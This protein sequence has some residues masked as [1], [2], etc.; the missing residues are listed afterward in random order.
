MYEIEVKAV[1]FLGSSE[2]SIREA[3]REA[4]EK[5]LSLGVQ[6][7]DHRIQTDLY[8]QHPSLDYRLT[9]EAFRIRCQEWRG[10]GRSNMEL[11]YKGPRISERTKTRIEHEVP[12]DPTASREGT[13]TLFESLGFHLSKEVAK[14]R[15]TFDHGEIALCIDV[16][17]GLGAFM[18]A[19]VMGDDIEDGEGRILAFLKGNGWDDIENRSYME[20][21][22][23]GQS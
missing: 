18:E 4:R 7:R 3:A 14:E 5:L 9:D 21:L 8:L 19:E 12:L 6:E 17:L 23:G 16:V 2:A 1:L 20:L 22:E 10:E 13:L 15:W 11:T